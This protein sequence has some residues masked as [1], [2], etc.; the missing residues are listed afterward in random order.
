MGISCRREEWRSVEGLEAVDVAS[1]GGGDVY[2][3]SFALDKRHTQ[4]GRVKVMVFRQ[5]DLDRF[6]WMRE[7]ADQKRREAEDMARARGMPYIGGGDIT[8]APPPLFEHTV[9]HRTRART[10]THTQSLSRHFVCCLSL[11]LSL[12]RSL[13]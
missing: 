11:C 7:H 5:V 3:I 13:E 4:S 9:S 6:A 1:G 12:S 8:K 10:H 2:Q